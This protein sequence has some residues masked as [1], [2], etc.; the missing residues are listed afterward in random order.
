[1][2][3]GIILMITYGYSVQE[4]TDS[5]VDIADKVLDEFARATTPGALL[6]DV[7]PVLRYIPSWFPGAHF[8][9]L[10]AEWRDHLTQM[11]ETPFELVKK[12]MVRCLLYSTRTSANVRFYSETVQLFRVL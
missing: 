9:R 8:Q 11:V 6:V 3:A 1:M 7:L 10:A 2:A 5:Y 12:Q 4:G